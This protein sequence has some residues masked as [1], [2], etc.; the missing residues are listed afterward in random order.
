MWSYSGRSYGVGSSQGLQ[1]IFPLSATDGDLLGYNY[2][3]TGYLVDT[4]CSYNTTSA[5]TLSQVIF[6]YQPANGSDVLLN[7]FVANGTLPNA[8]DDADFISYPLVSENSTYGGG[9]D[10]LT[11]AANSKHGANMISVVGY[12]AYEA[13]DTMQCSVNFTQ[14]QFQVQINVTNSTII[15]SPGQMNQDDSFDGNHHLRSNT[16]AS[17]SLLAQTAS[18]VA[19][20]TLGESLTN[21]WLTYNQSI[22]KIHVS[23]DPS[24]K[25][26]GNDSSILL[27]AED[28]FNAMLDDI[29][30]G[31][32]AAQFFWG[33]DRNGDNVSIMVPVTSAYNSTR[34]GQDG[35]IFAT[36]AIN[37]VL[38]MIGVEEA[39][40]TRNWKQMPR[41][42][43]LD[44]KSVIV[45][46][47]AGGKDVWED[48]SNRHPEGIKWDGNS[49]SKEVAA[50]RVRLGQGSVNSP[51]AHPVIMLAQTVKDEDVADGISEDGIP[52]R[53]WHSEH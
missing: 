24:Q 40:R 30:V 49:S 23:Y 38:I 28:S 20:N 37:V 1:G 31:Y 51:G 48:C 45:A 42:D 19:F 2:T 17:L 11:W 53:G 5:F 52:L 39:V 8:N 41:L 3:E 9:P 50:I 44:L 33:E 35:Y 29:L 18:S 32:G 15:V 7:I 14:T 6:D 25:F 16:M 10:L 26:I 27:A 12:G 46:A 22:D 43:Y 13:Y 47:S 34:L 36:L 4:F 21:N